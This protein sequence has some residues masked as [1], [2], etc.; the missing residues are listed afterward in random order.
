MSVEIV[1]GVRVDEAYVSVR[2]KDGK[3][4]EHHV[5]HALGSIRRPMNDAQ[6]DDKFMDLAQVVMTRD[7]AERAL[8]A[9]RGVDSL[10]SAGEIGQALARQALQT[11]STRTGA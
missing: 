5:E 1:P 2:L 8:Q 9:C 6:I 3:L 10:A 11:S 7:Q 4:L